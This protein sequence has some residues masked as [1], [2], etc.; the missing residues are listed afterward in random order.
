MEEWAEEEVEKRKE[1]ADDDGGRGVRSKGRRRG[2]IAEVDEGRRW[3]EK[4]NGEEEQ[5]MGKKEDEEW[6][7]ETVEGK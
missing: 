1:E 5:E 7:E 4:K 3:L 6:M 2:M